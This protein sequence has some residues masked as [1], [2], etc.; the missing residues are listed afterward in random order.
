MPELVG[1]S[2]TKYRR[3]QLE[4]ICIW[5]VD[6][7]LKSSVHDCPGRNDF[8]GRRIE[9][10]LKS[11]SDDFRRQTQP[12]ENAPVRV[13]QNRA[14]SAAVAGIRIWGLSAHV[15]S[16]CQEVV[17]G[18]HITVCGKAAHRQKAAAIGDC[19]ICGGH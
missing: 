18:F 4:I 8:S 10:T 7:I 2:L 14:L 11:E 15:A 17:D 1:E 19:E 13:K 5:I 9:C 3:R 16:H 12:I 6:S